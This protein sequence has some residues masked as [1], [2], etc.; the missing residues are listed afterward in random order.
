MSEKKLCIQR[1]SSKKCLMISWT[2]VG[3][4]NISIMQ[5]IRNKLTCYYVGEKKFSATEGYVSTFKNKYID[6]NKWW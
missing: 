4:F 6:E 5:F 3:V 2:Y 1:N